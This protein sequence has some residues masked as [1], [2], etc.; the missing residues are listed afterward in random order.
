MYLP[1]FN[2]KEITYVG[3]Q[4]LKREDLERLTAVECGENIFT[5]R[6]QQ[7]EKWIQVTPWVK[8]A[9]VKRVLP[10][11][12]IIEIE[13]REPAFLVLYYT[14][15]LLVSADGA[16]L[17]PYSGQLEHFPIVTGVK[18]HDPALPG[19][20]L[21]DPK[22]DKLLAAWKQFPDSFLAQVA[23]FHLHEEGDL[24]IYLE[25][26]LEIIFGQATEVTEKLSLIKQ[27]LAETECTVKTVN[28]W[29]GKRAHVS[30]EATVLES[31]E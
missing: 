21:A 25:D 6:P 27:A 23:E 22:L 9:T 10:N 16:L 2:L 3:N 15:F 7:I 13:E 19:E 24:V 31:E 28:V 5:I 26:G 1:V 29:S 8:K 30:L 20:L 12:L 11:E 18:I 4:V 17:G 14:S